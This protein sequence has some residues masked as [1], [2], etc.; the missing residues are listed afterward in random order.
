MEIVIEKLK[1]ED[2][3]EAIS[4]Y[5]ENYNLKTNYDRLF[6]IYDKI[7]HN[8]LYHNIVA[9]VNGKIVAMATVILHYDIVEQCRPFLT[10]WNF[11]VK[12]EFRKNKI[13]TQMFEYI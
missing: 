8:P 10:V 4:I 13:G 7:D 12:K 9:K 2:L 6:H 3:K 1:N 5:D 11:G